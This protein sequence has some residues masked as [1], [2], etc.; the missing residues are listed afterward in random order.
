MPK[1]LI[2]VFFLLN[3]TI[4]FSQPI[5]AWDEVG[6]KLT[7]YIAWQQMNPQARERAI[8][9]L[10]SSPEDADLSVFY[11]Q[12]SRSEAAVK[13][14]FFM[15]AATW[16]DIIRDREFKNRYAKYFHGTWHYLDT[17][18][19]DN[20][21]KVELLP[22][23][24]SDKE[25]AVE[26]L[27]FFDKQLRDATVPDSDK[28]LALAWVLHLAGD[29]HQPLHTSGRVTP[30]DPKGGDAGGNTFLLNPKD[31]PRER[32]ENLHWF[33]DS[34]VKRSIP[35]KND[36]CDSDYLP[37]IA[38][39][40]MTKYPISKMQER[41][42]IGK[43]D[44]WQQEG[45]QIA[46]TKLYPATLIRFEKPSEDYKKMAFEVSQEQI[47]LAGYRMG[48]MLNQILGSYD[49]VASSGNEPCLI[50]RKVLYPVSKTNSPDQKLEIGLLNLCPANTGMMARPMYPM[51]L[52]GELKMREYDVDKIFK[53]EAEA[54]EY[55]GK[56][57]I[58]DISF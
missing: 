58:K 28:A 51:M 50:I 52:N 17:F 3:V 26:R 47:A 14:E 40:M 27:F 41:L 29:I 8:K 24:E 56:N 55:A 35:H 34:I 54:R 33:W 18:W 19:K 1:L 12:N 42:N 13:M 46:S 25:N 2:S 6:H 57:S 43:F 20:N 7:A 49:V 48:A 36:E 44:V 38:E 32:S 31:T 4:F 53:T 23:M 5:F 10:R 22:D 16:A 45:F 11:L 30:E 21:G 37:P 15:L 39:M 9:L